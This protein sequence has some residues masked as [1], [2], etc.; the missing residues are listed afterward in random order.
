MNKDDAS[1]NAAKKPWTRSTF[2][3]AF[4][5]CI[6]FFGPEP[7]FASKHDDQRRARELD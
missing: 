2:S 1:S 4:K 7:D 6:L 5:L 3:R